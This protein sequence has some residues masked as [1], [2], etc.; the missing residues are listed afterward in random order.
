MWLTFLTQRNRYKELNKLR[1]QR[2]VSQEQGKTTARDLST[3][4][5]SNMPDREFIVMII[6]IL[7]ELEK[8]IEDTMRPLRRK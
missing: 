6:K 2:N 7:T 3:T 5:V 4:E 1:R 8:R